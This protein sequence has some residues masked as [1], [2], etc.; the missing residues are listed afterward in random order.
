MI[1]NKRVKRRYSFKERDYKRIK[2]HTIKLL[3]KRANMHDY[4]KVKS[5]IIKLNKSCFKSE[6]AF[7]YLIEIGQ[8]FKE[9]TFYCNYPIANLYYGDF[10]D[11]KKRLVIEIDGDTHNCPKQKK[12]DRIKK[13]VIEGLGFKIIRFTN[14]EILSKVNDD[15]I[16]AYSK[17]N[18]ALMKKV[19]NIKIVKVFKTIKNKKLKFD[20][21]KEIKAKWAKKDKTVIIK[22]ENA[23]FD[24][25]A[26]IKAEFKPKF[27]LRKKETIIA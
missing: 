2:H 26:M 17:K 4:R 18:K 14:E 21:D 13:D 16:L 9:N 11:I 20:K 25:M 8:E 19:K 27:I 23:K 3:G 6:I 1:I 10:V 15:L 12:R 7:Q 22:K 24:H 5:R